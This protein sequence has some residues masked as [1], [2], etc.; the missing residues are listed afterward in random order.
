MPF[1]LDVSI[2]LI[3]EVISLCP[4]I[5]VRTGEESNESTTASNRKYKME[6]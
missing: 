5:I 3:L 4:K 2:I 6:S 1:T